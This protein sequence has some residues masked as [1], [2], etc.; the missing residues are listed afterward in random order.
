MFH[1]FSMHI[2]SSLNIPQVSN[3]HGAGGLVRKTDIKLRRVKLLKMEVL[4]NKWEVM[5]GLQKDWEK[6]DNR[7]MCTL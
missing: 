3:R 5:E 1:L 6:N 2:L 7:T 4:R